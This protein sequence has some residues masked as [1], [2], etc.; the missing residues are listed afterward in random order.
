[1][2]SA[3]AIERRYG[4]IIGQRFGSLTAIR[5][6]DHRAARSR[7]LGVFCCVCGVVVTKPM[8]RVIAGTVALHCGCET[9]RGA[10]RTH[11]QH[12]SPAYASWIAM[13]R[14]CLDSTHKDFPRYGAKGIGIS[15]QWT[16][17]F[18]AFYHDMGDRPPGTTLD[19][20][21]GSKG[22]SAANCRWATPVEQAR[23][24]RVFTVVQ[25]P[26]GTMPLID[27]A[28][29]VGLTKGAAHLRLKRGKL[30]GVV[31]V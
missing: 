6:S 7:V 4:A 28:E 9:P 25:T 18:A 13:K 14:R 1:M 2:M 24:R 31:R 26:L 30:E 17:S 19:R 10:N 5:L 8:A 27:Y 12:R 29:A 3:T 23:N 21:D 20:I 11:G 15:P 16:L 22:Y